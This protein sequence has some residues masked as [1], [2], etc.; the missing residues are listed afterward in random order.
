MA[1]PGGLQSLKQPSLSL[2][3]DPGTALP[4]PSRHRLSWT[5]GC[6]RLG[7]LC[8]WRV[9]H[10]Q[11]GQA[12]G[13][14]RNPGSI[15]T[16]GFTDEDYREGEAD[17]KAHTLHS[18]WAWRSGKRRFCP[19]NGVGWPSDRVAGCATLGKSLTCLCALLWKFSVQCRP[20]VHGDPRHFLRAR[21]SG[22]PNPA[23][24][25]P[26]PKHLLCTILT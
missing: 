7:K 2:C 22:T 9:M 17:P 24:P 11:C 4:H 10:N 1:H 14:I 19:Q 23:P 13:D 6:L 26:R 18:T 25:T 20:R 8:G 5:R 3:P 15:S 16:S 12:T 21:A